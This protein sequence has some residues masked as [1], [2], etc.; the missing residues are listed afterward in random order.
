MKM[1]KALNKMTKTNNQKTIHIQLYFLFDCTD[2]IMM[3]TKRKLN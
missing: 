2:T 3:R 1:I